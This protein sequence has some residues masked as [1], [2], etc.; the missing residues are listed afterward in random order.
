MFHVEQ[1]S[2]QQRVDSIAPPSLGTREAMFHVQH[3]RCGCNVVR[4]VPLEDPMRVVRS[5]MFHVDQFGT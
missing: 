3:S 4:P 5:R 1:T 2:I